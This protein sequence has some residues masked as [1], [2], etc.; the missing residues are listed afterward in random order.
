M[1]VSWSPGWDFT[2]CPG[3]WVPLELDDQVVNNRRVC[4]RDACVGIEMKVLVAIDNSSSSQAVIDALVKM[5][6]S[7]GTEICLLTVLPGDAENADEDS[8]SHAA[9][10]EMENL[11]LEL[12]NSLRNCEVSF[13]A[14]Y[15]EP[16]PLI[17]DL[18]DRI[19]AELI[20]LGSNCKSTLERLLL[21]SVSESVLSGAKCPVIVAKTPCCL[22][23]EASPEFRK[24]LVTIDNSVFS[25]VA[26]SWLGNFQW[27][28][29]T[30]FI[31]A[32]VIEEDTDIASVNK[33][34]KKRATTLSHLLNTK[35]VV[36]EIAVGA[37]HHAI[38]DLATK[39]Y[40]DLI[41]MGSHG[42]T[43]IKEMILGQVSHQV[44]HLAS[45]AVA[46]VR[47]IDAKDRSNHSEDF[48]KEEKI[49]AFTAVSNSSDGRNRNTGIHVMP[50]GF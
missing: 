27:G 48:P 37:P 1:L 18:A 36:T 12:R 47:G 30:K 25:D 2:Y 3:P 11:A 23:R 42:H 7:E 40:T 41:L 19:H 49:P 33:S 29:G 35:N 34:L 31:V 26:V 10:E 9:F 32:A 46:I 20:V 6:W 21:G 14:R 13:L 44:S 24:I 4:A 5:H 28:P 39:H 38:V 43:G 17:L 50:G 8:K 22:A 15:G 16:K 45:C